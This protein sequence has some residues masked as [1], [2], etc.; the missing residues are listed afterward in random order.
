MCDQSC[1]QCS[2]CLKEQKK[3]HEID[4]EQMAHVERY[5]TPVDSSL[6][7]DL[8]AEVQEQ[9][10]TGESDLALTNVLYSHPNNAKP[11]MLWDNAFKQCMCS[12]YNTDKLLSLVIEKPKDYLMFTVWDNLIWKKNLC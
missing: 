2:T 5:E 11:D 3:Q 8:D 7:H 4:A 9:E 10:E 12:G 1:Q 6:P